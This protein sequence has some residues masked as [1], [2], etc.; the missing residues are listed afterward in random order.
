MW[1]PNRRGRCALH[2]HDSEITP[3]SVIHIS[4]SEA[5]AIANPPPIFGQSFSLNFGS[6]SI[7]VQNVTPGNGVV[8]FYVVVDFHAPL[9]VA[10]DITIFDPPVQVIIGT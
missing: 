4:A 10:T 2:F 1:V 5:T 3:N 8:D 7:S 6:A 9:N